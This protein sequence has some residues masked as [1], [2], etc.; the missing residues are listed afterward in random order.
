MNRHDRR[1]KLVREPT[2]RL[3]TGEEF[4][5]S[6]VSVD[7][8]VRAE[9]VTDSHTVCCYIIGRPESLSKRDAVESARQLKRLIRQI[10]PHSPLGLAVTGYDDDPRELFEI[11]EVK[12]YLAW[13]ATECD[14]LGV[15]ENRVLPG[16]RPLITLGRA[17][18]AGDILDIT[19]NHDRNAATE[20]VQEVA[21]F[22]SAAKGKLS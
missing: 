2:G 17:I 5:R 1:A 16:S 13:F 3:L 12:Q 10:S 11:E 18:A 6:A 14:A 21:E 7:D 19:V 9:A 4:A 8:F 20:L 22:Q 15:D